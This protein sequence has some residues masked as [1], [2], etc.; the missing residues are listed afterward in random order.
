MITDTKDGIRKDTILILG[1]ESNPELLDNRVWREFQRDGTSLR[2]V[3][4]HA[5]AFHD[6]GMII[7]RIARQGSS[8]TIGEIEKT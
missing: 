2:F 4:Y 1:I 3:G 6:H 7:H 5:V 8:K